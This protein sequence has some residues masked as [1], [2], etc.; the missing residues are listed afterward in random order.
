[1]RKA[2]EIFLEQAAIKEAKHPKTAPKIICFSL[3][4][5]F[6]GLSIVLLG[7]AHAPIYGAIG[8]NITNGW[9]A[10]VLTVLAIFTIQ[11]SVAFSS[12]GVT[13]SKYLFHCISSV[14]LSLSLLMDLGLALYY[15]IW[16][17]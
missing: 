17:I 15:F 14:T 16:V 8:S 12:V 3:A 5:A 11:L 9:V 1:M 13:S 6:F 7:V 4:M 2:K 10:L